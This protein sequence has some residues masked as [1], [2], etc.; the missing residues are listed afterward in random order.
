[1]SI[2]LYIIPASPTIITP[3]KLKESFVSN[4]LATDRSLLEAGFHIIE[5]GPNKITDGQTLKLGG[6]YYFE[7][8][9][10]NTLSVHVVSKEL[11]LEFQ[12]NLEEDILEDYG[13]NLKSEAILKIVSIFKKVDHYYCI[14]THG[15]R[16]KAEP[17]LFLVLAKAIAISSSGY[18]VV[19]NNDILDLGVGVYTYDE[20]LFTKPRF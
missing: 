18:I 1:M 7:M 14:T 20:F 5:L 8:S 3:D 6:V 9:I 10:P 12:Q 4:L 19:M 15:G 13:W 11:Q 2:D 16:S 17:N